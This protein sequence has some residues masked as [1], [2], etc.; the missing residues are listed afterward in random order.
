MID[1]VRA[2]LQRRFT[3]WMTRN[4]GLLTRVSG[5]LLVGIGVLGIVVDLT[6]NL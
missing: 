4:Y 5:I 1:S 6:P 2:P 3:G